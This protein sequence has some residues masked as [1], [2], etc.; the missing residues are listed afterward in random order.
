MDIIL[1]IILISGIWLLSVELRLP[2]SEFRKLTTVNS[3]SQVLVSAGLLAVFVILFAYLSI[4]VVTN[5]DD[6]F[7]ALGR[8][9]NSN[10]LLLATSILGTILFSFYV[11][12]AWRI[13]QTKNAK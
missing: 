11:Y 3:N 12:R 13:W 6:S 5:F 10:L 4:T 7:S 1:G 8:P 9:I 2:R